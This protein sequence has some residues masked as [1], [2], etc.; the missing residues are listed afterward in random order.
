[1]KKILLI[2]IVI[3]LAIPNI[4]ISQ[5]CMESSS[6]DGVTVS[7]YIQPQYE[8]HQ[9]DGLYNDESSFTFE[10]AR[11]GFF[12]N[13]PYDISYYAFIETSAFKKANPYLLDAFVTY[14]R[15]GPWAKISLGQFKSPFSLELNTACHG[16]HTVKR[17][18]VVRD[19]ATPDRDIGLMISGGNDTTFFKY[20]FAITNGTG[21]GNADN[22][23]RKDFS[24]RLVLQPF[25][26]LSIGG[27][28][29]TG[30]SKSAVQGQPEDTK[31]R[32]AAELQVKFENILF[33]GE[34]LMGEDD[35]SYTTGGGCGDPL[36]THIGSVSRNGYWA[37]LMYMTPWNLQPI[38]KF[39][40]YEPNTA[41]GLDQKSIITFGINYFLNDWTR[42]QINYL[43]SAEEVEIENDQLFV[44]V[45]VKF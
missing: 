38:V 9:K 40:S 7:G 15:F 1:M 24:G 44:Q 31:T 18:Q 3:T 14:T 45:Q 23:T 17:S 19:L 16:L 27:S 12:G 43:Y 42:I 11:F 35:G 41:L 2:V 10:R 33:Q 20:A 37:H 26:F 25:E 8:F 39:E 28:F 21:L 5:G 30:K 32:Y 6:D 29:R 4:A 22:N 13:I 34:Y 36:V